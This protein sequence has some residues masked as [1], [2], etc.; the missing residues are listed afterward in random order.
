MRLAASAE[1][2]PFDRRAERTQEPKA[3]FPELSAAVSLKAAGHL[4]QQHDAQAAAFA[5]PDPP[6]VLLQRASR[7]A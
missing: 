4:I 1:Q 6:T 5:A 3:V 7:A 2:K